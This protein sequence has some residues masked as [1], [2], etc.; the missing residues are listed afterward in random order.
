MCKIPDIIY[1]NSYI[2]NTIEFKIISFSDKLRSAQ[3]RNNVRLEIIMY[4]MPDI[5]LKSSK[6]W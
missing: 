4:K 1:N 3:L 5:I 6:N 2:E